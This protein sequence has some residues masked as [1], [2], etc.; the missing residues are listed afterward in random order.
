[1]RIIYFL[2]PISILF[3]FFSILFF[4]W[5]VNNGQYEDFDCSSY[6][7][8]LDDMKNRNNFDFFKKM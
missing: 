1:M 6:H 8:L 3:L 5:A 2:I 4:F 7:I